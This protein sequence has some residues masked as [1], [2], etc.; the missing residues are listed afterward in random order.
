MWS[1]HAACGTNVAQTRRSYDGIVVAGIDGRCGV[2]AV[3][4]AVEAPTRGR[5]TEPAT[6]RWPSETASGRTGRRRPGGRRVMTIEI[7]ELRVA[8]QEAH[9]DVAGLTVAV[10]GNDQ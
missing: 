9:P 6:G 2:R 3:G 8:S 10:L 1:F 4:R 7:D 5:A